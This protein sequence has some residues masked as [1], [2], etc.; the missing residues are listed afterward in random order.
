M[1][2]TYYIVLSIFPTEYHA[3]IVTRYKSKPD[4]YVAAVINLEGMILQDGYLL[5]RRDDFEVPFP[6]KLQPGP[7]GNIMLKDTIDDFLKMNENDMIM[8]ILTFRLDRETN[9][10]SFASEDNFRF[11]HAKQHQLEHVVVDIMVGGK[12]I[13]L[14]NESR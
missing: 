11:T 5:V 12:I 4:A 14:K 9:W 10:R 6:N 13:L 8:V 3:I 1:F 2:Y 7:N